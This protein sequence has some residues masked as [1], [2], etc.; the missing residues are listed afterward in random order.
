MEIT[1]PIWIKNSIRNSFL[2]KDVKA[3]KKL[4]STWYDYL[5]K[6][7]LSKENTKGKGFL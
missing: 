7:V 4:N 5:N 2:E 3:I 6:H 1:M